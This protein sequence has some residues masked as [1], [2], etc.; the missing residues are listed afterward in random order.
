MAAQ[1]LGIAVA[2]DWPPYRRTAFSVPLS[3]GV[4]RKISTALAILSVASLLVSM[5]RMPSASPHP[6]RPGPRIVRAGIWTVHFGI[7]NEGYDSQRRIRDLV[8]YVLAYILAL[9]SIQSFRRD[10]ELDIVGLLET[11]LHVRS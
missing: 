1:M 11:D 10:M 6:H 2:V 3:G 5:Y 8:R 9:S 4:K 7:D